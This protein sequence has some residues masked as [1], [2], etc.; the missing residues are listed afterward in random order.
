MSLKNVLKY[1]FL[2]IGKGFLCS[3]FLIIGMVIGGI[4]SAIFG[5][6]QPTMPESINTTLTIL[7]MIPA[8]IL[9]A[10][11]L[12]ELFKK[13]NQSFFERLFCL[14][15]FNYIIEGFEKPLCRNLY[16]TLIYSLYI[17]SD[18]GEL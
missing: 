14:F 2:S 1:T 4:F 18:E 15:L 13:L 9:I 6:K 5:L 12:G 3:L 17:R 8:G 16:L 10:I 7:L 11:T